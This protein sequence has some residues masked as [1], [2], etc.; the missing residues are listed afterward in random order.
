[1]PRH[2]ITAKPVIRAAVVGGS[3]ELTSRSSPLAQTGSALPILWRICRGTQHRAGRLQLARQRTS[4]ARWLIA[5]ALALGTAIAPAATASADTVRLKLVKT[6]RTSTFA[7]PSPDPSGIVYRPGRD[8]LLISDSEVDETRRY[9]GRNLFTARRRG[10]GFG[11]GNLVR[12]GNREP[13]DLGSNPKTGTL[14]ASNDD[15]DRIL[16]IRPGRDGVHGS[17][18]DRVSAFSTARFGSTDPEGVEYDPSTGRLFI[19]DG[20][21]REVYAVDPVNGRFGDGNDRVTHFDVARYG[22]RD[23]EGLGIDR[24]GPHRLLA[25]DW[26]SRAIYKLNRRGRLLRK[27]SLAAIRTRRSVVADVTMAPTSKRG[28]KPGHLSYWIVDRHLDNKNHPNENDG[29]VHEMVV[30]R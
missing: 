8:R 23:C 6:F 13:S 10:S 21:D 5:G 24:R 4:A 16:R 2:R 30:R 1:M 9:R 22:A 26:M 25:V 29:L 7:P 20:R 14:F 19:C 27:F 28:D 11:S 15:R 3:D 12:I 18:D 17:Q